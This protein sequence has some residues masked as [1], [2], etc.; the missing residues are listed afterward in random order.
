MCFT[1]LTNLSK[2][3]EKTRCLKKLQGDPEKM[4]TFTKVVNVANVYAFW[5]TLTKPSLSAVGLHWIKFIFTLDMR[6]QL[7]T[8]NQCKINFTQPF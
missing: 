6:Q 8:T 1:F 7:E 5:V 3:P 2:I 4:Y